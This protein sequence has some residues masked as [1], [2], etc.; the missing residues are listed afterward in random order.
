MY[1][2]IVFLD[3]IPRLV[4]FKHKVSE[5]GFCIRFQEKPIQ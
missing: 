1:I 4:L 3:I 2:I 5:T